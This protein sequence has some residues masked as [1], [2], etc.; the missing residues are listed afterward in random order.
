M[1][2]RSRQHLL[3]AMRDAFLNKCP[4]I[5][6][7]SYILFLSRVHEKKGADL[8]I[9]AYSSI[10]NSSSPKLIIA[11]PGME[12]DY[13]KTLIQLVK[14]NHL[15]DS[16]HFAGMLSGDA[17]WGAFYGC[18]SFAL[19]SHQENFGISVAEAL[20]C[21]KPVLISNQVNIWREIKKGGGGLV[22]TDTLEGTKNSLD[23]WFNLSHDERSKMQ[24]RARDTYKNNFA[25]GPAAMQMAHAL[26]SN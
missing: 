4:E 10:R 12:T 2:Y 24:Q 18:D 5:A 26:N 9:K 23:R 17:K 7:K 22:S 8:L 11:G 16:V 20:A 3:L 25:I 13:G 19:P 15:E 14:E 6:D 21:A 1:E